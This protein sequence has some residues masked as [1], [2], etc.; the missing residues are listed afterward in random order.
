[1]SLLFVLSAACASAARHEDGRVCL[2]VVAGK[3][4]MAGL[5]VMIFSPQHHSMS[6]MTD[7]AGEVAFRVPAGEWLLHLD[8]GR[9]D[10]PHPV[11]TVQAGLDTFLAVDLNPVIGCGLDDRLELP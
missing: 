8:T 11:V 4:P 2:D 7:A 9:D 1:M 5:H 6:A 3:S 10:Q